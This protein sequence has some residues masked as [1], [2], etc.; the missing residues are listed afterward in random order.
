M[1]DLKEILL[2]K[3]REKK[4]AH[5]YI[6]SA[7]LHERNPEAALAE[8]MEQ[9]LLRVIMDEKQVP[10]TSARN[11]LQLG[12]GDILEI[13]KESSA[14]RY[15]TEDF[16]ELLYFQNYYNFEFSHR[17]AIVHN[18]QQI[19]ETVANK[20]LKTL[21]EPRPGT[22]IFFLNSSNQNFISTIRSRAIELRLPSTSHEANQQEN[23]FSSKQEQRSWL[24]HEGNLRGIESGLIEDFIKVLENGLSPQEF[25][26]NKKIEREMW[27]RFLLLLIDFHRLSPGDYLSKKILLEELQWFQV[28]Q[29]FGQP[30]WERFLGLLSH[31]HFLS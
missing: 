15:T 4:L 21:E 16:E 24:L 6:L 17:F 19:S 8:W 26:N 3:Y 22:T 1:L 7:G 31:T 5:F 12:H 29:V 14:D 18:A 25:L 23:I 11:I 28:A 20:L 9:F 2:S 30:Q 27:Q 10:E 13:K